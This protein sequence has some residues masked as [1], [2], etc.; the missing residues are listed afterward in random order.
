MAAEAKQ[1]NVA[2]KWHCDWGKKWIYRNAVPSGILAGH[3][4]NR[5]YVTRNE[6]EKL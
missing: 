4:M 3:A 6:S 2:L 5:A 1:E